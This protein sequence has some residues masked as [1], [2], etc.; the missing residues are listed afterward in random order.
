MVEERRLRRVSRPAER[1]DG[2]L[3]RWY[4]LPALVFLV[5]GPISGV[6]P[7]WF[8][9]W[10]LWGLAVALLIL[11]L[12][13]VAQARQHRVTL[14]PV[15]AVYTIAWFTAVAGWSVRDLRVEAFSLPLGLALLGAGVLAMKPADGSAL[16]GRATLNSWPIRFTGSWPLLAPGIIATLLP[17]MLATG[18]DPQTW[19]A[20]TVLALALVAILIGSLRKLG[21]PFLLGIIAL[22]IEIAIVFAV[23]IGTTISATWWWITLATAGAV[24]L[25]I[26][27]TYE[28]R[29]GGDKG[30]AA[31]MRDLA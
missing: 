31:R 30:L 22:P 19:R 29:S 5:A 8:P 13:I 1:S 9:I 15:W 23:Q 24:L 12:V 2:F 11:M 21:A 4:Y 6:R 10:T 14:P 27:T 18:T 28:R 3:T 7:G 26:A 20:I 17:S 16:A 25:V